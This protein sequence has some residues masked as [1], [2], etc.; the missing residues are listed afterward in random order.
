MIS[1]IPVP[2]HLQPHRILHW[3]HPPPAPQQFPPISLAVAW[4]AFTR[5]TDYLQYSLWAIR[6]D[7]SAGMRNEV[8]SPES[9]GLFYFSPDGVQVAL[10][11]PDSISMAIAD[12]S[13]LRERVL[14]YPRVI[15]YSEYHYYASPVWAPG[16]S[17]FLFVVRS[18]ANVEL[19]MRSITDEEILIASLSAGTVPLISY[20]FG[21]AAR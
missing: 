2:R 8:L 13:G 21:G 17:H 12:G 15:T 11:Q 7:G 10:V 19:R 3:K 1:R 14:V 20:D 9:G 4:I 5:T 18:G 16:A 6:S